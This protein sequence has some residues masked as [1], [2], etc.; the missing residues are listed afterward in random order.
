MRRRRLALAMALTMAMTS[1]PT[2]GLVG[3]A[4]EVVAEQNISAVDSSPA[5]SEAEGT[6]AQDLASELSGG[7]ASRTRR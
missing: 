2:N 3:Y 1:V 5:E 6:D 7:G 4:E